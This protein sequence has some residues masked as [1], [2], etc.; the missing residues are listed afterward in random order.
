MQFFSYY[1]SN[2]SEAMCFIPL[3]GQLLFPQLY[4]NPYI[5][6]SPKTPFMAI[7]KYKLGY[8]RISTDRQDVKSQKLELL[9]YVAP[10]NLYEDIGVSGTVSA[11][12][13]KGFKKVYDRIQKGEVS[14][15]YIFEMSRLGRTSSESIQLFIEIEQLGCKII[16]LS[17][18][19]S[20]TK[21]TNIDGIRNIFVSM[22][23]WFGDIERKSIS[24]RTK[25]GLQ[26]ARAQGKHLGRPY[27]EPNRAKYEKIKNDNPKLKPAQIAMI[28]QIPTTTFYRYLDKWDE[29]DRIENN[30]KLIGV[31]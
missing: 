13:R 26:N 25:L 10:E 5:V 12:K 22:F 24:E 1:I 7:E 16:S 23:A 6:R 20:W 2:F 11:K 14:E 15:L 28:M 19:E 4:T 21:I 3:I 27:R 31:C 18:N 30:K 29:E 8:C 17:P 9:K